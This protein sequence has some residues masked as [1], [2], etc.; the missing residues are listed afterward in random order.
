[1]NMKKTI[2]SLFLFAIACNSY[3]ISPVD[4]ENDLYGVEV[5]YVNKQF[6][7][8]FPNGETFHEDLFGREDHFLHGMQLGAYYQPMI[9]NIFGLRTGLYWE[10]YF[11]S[12]ESMGYDSF[13]EG[14][15]YIPLN[16]VVTIPIKETIAINLLGGI[17][18]NY[19]VFGEL[20]SRDEY[21][22]NN[23]ENYVPLLW[24]NDLY[25]SRYESEYLHYGQDGWPGR[26][27]AQY[28]FG[29]RVRIDG[30]S[31]RGTYSRGVTNHKFYWDENQRQ[32]TRERK[33]TIS[34]GYIF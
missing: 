21:W 15:I 6:V 23:Y 7:T 26:F 4:Y 11:S 3:S 2:I 19:I 17:S 13:T 25:N 28:E 14:N 27:N 33:L 31:I 32:R 5:G 22:D 9:N 20:S 10:Q 30:L 8:R 29:L 1:M 16:A 12:G 34:I 18:M 24:I